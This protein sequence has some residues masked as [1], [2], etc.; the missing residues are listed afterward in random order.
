MFRIFRMPRQKL[1]DSIIN[2]TAACNSQWTRSFLTKLSM[3]MSFTI[4]TNYSLWDVKWN[5][6]AIQM[7]KSSRDAEWI[8]KFICINIKRDIWMQQEICLLRVNRQWCC[9]LFDIIEMHWHLGIYHFSYYG[10]VFMHI[11]L[12]I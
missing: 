4:K 6:I 7:E 5:W 9:G 1:Y 11:L 10:R 8:S 12:Y 3:C 2:A